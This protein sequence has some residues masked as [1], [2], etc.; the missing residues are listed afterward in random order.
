MTDQRFSLGSAVPDW[1]GVY[2]GIHPAREITVPCVARNCRGMQLTSLGH[3]AANGNQACLLKVK[4]CGRK[5]RVAQRGRQSNRYCGPGSEP[6]IKTT[7]L[8]RP[9]HHQNTVCL[10]AGRLSRRAGVAA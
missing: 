6:S 2:H 5:V 3:R 8:L 4:T 1:T 10:S 7:G 9:C